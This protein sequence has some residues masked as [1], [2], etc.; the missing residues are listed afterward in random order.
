MHIVRQSYSSVRGWISALTPTHR[1]LNKDGEAAAVLKRGELS[2]YIR[3]HS[4][5]H[6]AMVSRALVLMLAPGIKE[7][8]IAGCS[9]GTVSR[10]TILLQPY[11]ATYARQESLQQSRQNAKEALNLRPYIPPLWSPCKSST[12][13]GFPMIQLFREGGQ[14]ILGVH[15]EFRRDVFERLP[16]LN[17]YSMFHPWCARALD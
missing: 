3:S 6:P 2:H 10:N 5:R 12:F 8:S 17:F 9:I 7:V 16:R 14:K 13:S 15:S 4:L 1:E 11:Q